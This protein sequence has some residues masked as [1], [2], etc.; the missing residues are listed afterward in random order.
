MH[1]HTHTHTY[2]HTH[3]HT[4]MEITKGS[5]IFLMENIQ[6]FLKNAFSGQTRRILEASIAGGI[7]AVSASFFSSNLV[8]SVATMDKRLAPFDALSTFDTEIQYALTEILRIVSLFVPSLIC[9]TLLLAEYMNDLATCVLAAANENSLHATSTGS[10]AL[11]SYTLRQRIS[12]IISDIA[13]SLPYDSPARSK[14]ESFTQCLY[15]FALQMDSEVKGY[16]RLA[17]RV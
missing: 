8:D 12:N 2:I 16:H 14:A 10:I 9:R 13:I 1:A 17:Q 6:I 4:N 3:T 5:G 7:V 15:D 11:M